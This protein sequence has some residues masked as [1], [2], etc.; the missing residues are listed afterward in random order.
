MLIT[1]SLLVDEPL[2]CVDVRGVIESGLEEDHGRLPHASMSDGPVGP[3][4]GIGD[5]DNVKKTRAVGIKV[6]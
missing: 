5:D 6:K 3:L 1:P 2:S 4:V